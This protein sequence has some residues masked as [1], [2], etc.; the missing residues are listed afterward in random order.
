MDILFNLLIPSK[1]FSEIE[2]MNDF[3]ELM[4]ANLVKIIDLDKCV[5]ASSSKQKK[6]VYE[7]LFV[8]KA[9]ETESLLIHAKDKCS[10]DLENKEL[11]IFLLEHPEVYN[12]EKDG[13]T[14]SLPQFEYSFNPTKPKSMGQGIDYFPS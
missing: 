10:L 12:I 3:V 9:Q 13:Q 6:K 5:S 4:T 1:N 2:C 11:V 14:V 8:E 7:I